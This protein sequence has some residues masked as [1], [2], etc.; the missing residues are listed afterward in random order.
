MKI[1]AIAIAAMGFAVA[2]SAVAA[3]RISDV[4][5]LKA[6]RC[7]GLATSL[8]SPAEAVALDAFVKSARGGRSAFVAERADAEFDRAKREA[9]NQ[10]RK[11]QLSAELTGACQAYTAA[12]Q[13]AVAKN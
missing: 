10:G 12:A 6:N 3:E 7:K 5:Y 8:G 9:R 1:A 13:P 2:G 4:E 11:D